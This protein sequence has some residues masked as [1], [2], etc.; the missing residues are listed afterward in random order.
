MLEKNFLD[1]TLD[2]G[3]PKSVDRTSRKRRKVETL[4]VHHHHH[5]T[6]LA[7]LNDDEDDAEDG[8]YQAIVVQGKKPKLG[9]GYAGDAREDVWFKS[10]LPVE[11]PLKAL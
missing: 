5:L 8:Y 1:D 11:L 4:P 6:A 10:S 7:D 9:T 3:G 2:Q